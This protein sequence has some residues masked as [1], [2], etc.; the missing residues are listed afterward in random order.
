[1]NEV[2][3][4]G[5]D[6]AQRGVDALTYQWQLD[7]Q[8]RINERI[9][10]QNGETFTAR[11]HQ[12]QALADEWARANPNPGNNRYVLTSEINGAAFDGNGRAQGLAGDQ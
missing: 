5:G 11:E 6:A 8:A 4:V 7:E 10:R 9:Q 3:P 1:M 12:L 2:L